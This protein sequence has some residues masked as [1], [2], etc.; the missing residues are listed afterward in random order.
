M[1]PGRASDAQLVR[2]AVELGDPDAALVAIAELRRRLEALEA[3][4]VDSALRAGWSW[5]RIGVA[6]GITRRAAHARH[7]GRRRGDDRMAVAARARVVIERAR[8]EATRLGS[9]TI[10]TDH[11]LLGLALEADGPAAEAIAACRL[12]AEAIRKG[13]DDTR[14]EDDDQVR[15][16][17]PAFSPASLAVLREA[18][19]EA[20]QRGSDELDCDH[21]L[22]A[23]LREPGGRGQRLVM[24]LG[25][26]PRAVER[27]LNRA[28]EK[29]AARADAPANAPLAAASG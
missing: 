8:Q 3:A 28:C 12:V 24:A 6:L 11:L 25:K 17:S 1:R 7:A 20:V 4:Q 5:Q 18:L 2:R 10:E 21:L 26:T 13:L 9:V 14:R 29:R 19:R 16:R 27:R 22:L 15:T 23:L